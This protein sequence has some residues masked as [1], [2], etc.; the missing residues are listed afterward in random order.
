MKQK[1]QRES[2]RRLHIIMNWPLCMWGCVYVCARVSKQDFHL[3]VS[4]RAISTL[5][6]LFV[7]ASTDPSVSATPPLAPFFCRYVC[8]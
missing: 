7:L 5:C 8:V 6:I 3:S 4:A 1:K 2:L